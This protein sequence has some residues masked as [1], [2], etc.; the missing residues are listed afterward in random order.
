MSY[1]I[2]LTLIVREIIGLVI[3]LIGNEIISESCDEYQLSCSVDTCSYKDFLL[4][5]TLI[6]VFTMF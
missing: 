2:M 5:D 1:L 4:G 6:P 3:S